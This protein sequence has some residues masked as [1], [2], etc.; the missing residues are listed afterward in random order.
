MKIFLPLCVGLGVFTW[1][2]IAMAER[3]TYP[4][5]VEYIFMVVKGTLNVW[6]G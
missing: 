5:L 4:T 6:F 3:M 1:H 2:Y